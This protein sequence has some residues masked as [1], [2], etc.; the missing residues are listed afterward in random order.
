MN[1]PTCKTKTTVKDSRIKGSFVIRRRKCPC[2]KLFS[3]KEKIIKRIPTVK[4][5]KRPDW[6]KQ[7]LAKL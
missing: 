3:T 6:A 5:V 7:M 2:G 4:K 1:C